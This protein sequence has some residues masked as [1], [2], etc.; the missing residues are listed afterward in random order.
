MLSFINLPAR[1]IGL[2]ES[3]VSSREIAA[4][5]CLGL[6]LGFTPLNG[7]MAVLLVLFFF[8]FKLNR[9]STLLTLPLFKAAYL[10]GVSGILEKFGSYLLIDARILTGFWSLATGLPLIAY[11]DINNTLVAGGLVAS[12]ILSI[13][14]YFISKQISAVLKNAYAEKVKHSKIAKAVSGLKIAGKVDSALK[15]GEGISLDFKSIG[16]MLFGSVKKRI[17]ARKAPATGLRK[18]INITALAIFI[19][20]LLIIQFGIGLVVSPAAGSLI[21]KAVNGSSGAKISAERVNVWPLTLS[22]SMKGLK[23]FDP[24]KEDTRIVKADSASFGISPIALLCKRLVFSSIRLKGAELDLEGSPDGSFNIQHMAQLPQTK[25]GQAALSDIG[26]MWKTFT[27]NKDTIGKVFG[28]LKDKFSKAGQEK[29]KQAQ[30]A[31]NLART[32]TEM[33][34]GKLIKFKAGKRA[35]IFEIKKLAISDASVNLRPANSDPVQINRASIRLGGL[36]FDPDNGFAIGSFAIRGDV[37]KDADR[38]GGINISFSQTQNSADID[39]RLND[40]NLNAVRFAYQD[41]LPV[42]IPQGVIRLSSKTSVRGNVINSRTSLSLS[43]QKVEAKNAAQ[44]V[45]GVV[46]VATIAA[47]LNSIDPVNLK[48]TIGG[49]VERPEFGAFKESIMGLVDP[50]VA[51]LKNKIVQEGTEAIGKFFKNVTEKKQ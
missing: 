43:H 47:A 9:V 25:A 30:A 23:V 10:M 4:G 36:A 48:F 1:I 44:L 17:L 49:T 29:R 39:V 16:Q 22:F 33:P 38:Q 21:I 50:Y 41:S 2:L 34:K 18:R 12:T 11:L 40:L 19:L 6:F 13:P 45:F 26:S 37:Y 51:K 8:I 20:V 35:Y 42:N 5:V 14:L 28:F 27:Q 3:N 7:P 24:K 32:V 31:R 15:A 46:P